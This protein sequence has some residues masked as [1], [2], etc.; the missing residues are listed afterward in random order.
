MVGLE[1]M[2]LVSLQVS[3]IFVAHTVTWPTAAVLMQ[4]IYEDIV[5]ECQSIQKA[6]ILMFFQVAKFVLS[7]QY[8][9]I[10]IAK[11]RK[12]VHCGN[13]LIEISIKDFCCL[14]LWCSSLMY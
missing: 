6:D 7:F 3:V 12:R 1:M 14:Y 5:K 10:L 13:I 2:F 4:S 11:V 9:K 8:Q